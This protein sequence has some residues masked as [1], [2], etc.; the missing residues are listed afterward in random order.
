MPDRRLWRHFDFVMIGLIV[1]LLIGG[2]AMVRSATRG[3]PVIEGLPFAQAVTA[4]A[5]LGVMLLV[6]VTDYSLLKNVA[7]PLYALTLASLAAVLVFGTDRFGARRWFQIGSF[8]L[9]PG[10]IAKILL[11][12]VLAYIIS[13]RQG[14][15]PYFETI[16]LT[17]LAVA[18]CVFLIMRQ[19][20][21]STALTIVFIW[22]AIVFVGGIER[23]H[24][25]VMVVAGI[26]M[27]LIIQQLGLIQTYQVERIEKLLGINVA[28]GDTYQIDQ[29]RLALSSGGLTGLG[30]QSGT[31]SQLRLV[32]ARHTD[33]IYSVIGEEL[34]FAGAITFLVLILLV[35]A[36]ALRAAWLS[37][38]TFGRLLCVGVAAMLFLQTYTNVGMQLGI[39]P[40]T[41][42]VL[43]FVSYGRSNLLTLL[44]AVGI[45]ESVVMRH[46]R[47]E[48]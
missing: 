5:G 12:V 23:Q 34:G 11:T 33:F 14:R 18:P 22:L 16:G 29:A 30:Y 3:D 26:A 9:Q 28:A 17:L 19:P 7:I 2:I 1:A 41:G 8:D 36:R 48:F 44:A 38:D 43:P 37:R 45:V 32:P 46:R 27:I 40:V 47:L 42:V 24:A 20:N 13:S 39:L 10:E 6:V 25:V 31:F 15:R 35:I 21:L 4:L